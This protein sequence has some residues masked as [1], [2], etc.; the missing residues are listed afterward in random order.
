MIE[1]IP[2]NAEMVDVIM[3]G[4]AVCSC[5]LTTGIAE[6]HDTERLSGERYQLAEEQL[7]RTLYASFPYVVDR[8]YFLSVVKSVKESYRIKRHAEAREAIAKGDFCTDDDLLSWQP[9]K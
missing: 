2:I 4:L 3:G 5:S 1:T 9:G 6:N 7:V 8:Y